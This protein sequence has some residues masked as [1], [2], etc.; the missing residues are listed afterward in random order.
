M[1]IK[2]KL[3]YEAPRTEVVEVQIENALLQLSGGKYSPF[4]EEKI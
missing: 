2:N 1:D 3:T 4:D